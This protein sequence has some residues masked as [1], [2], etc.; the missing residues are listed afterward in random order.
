MSFLSLFRLRVTVWS[1]KSQEDSI[2][3][4][5]ACGRRLR[6]KEGGLVLNTVRGK[7]LNG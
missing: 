6:V 5:V 4:A 2:L 1:K 3:A 7:F